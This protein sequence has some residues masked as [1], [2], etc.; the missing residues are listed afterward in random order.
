MGNGRLQSLGVYSESLRDCDMV[1]IKIDEAALA[2]G[3][4]TRAEITAS[5]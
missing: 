3:G 2:A 1:E 4:I 5:P